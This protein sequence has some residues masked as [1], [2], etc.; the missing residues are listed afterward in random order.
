MTANQQNRAG[1]RAIIAR[2]ELAQ[3]ATS[4]LQSKEEVLQRERSRLAGH[5]GRSRSDW[6]RLCNEAS[7][8]LLRARVLGASDELTALIVRGPNPASVQADWQDSMGITYPGDV[9]CTPGAQFGVTGTAALLPVMIAYRAA[10]IAGTQHAGTATALERLDRELES[11]RR[12]R[13]AIGDHLVPRISAELHQLDLALDEQDREEAVRIRLA[14]GRQD[15]NRH[16]SDR[17]EAVRR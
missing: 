2:L 5:E 6:I 1:R 4:L 12:R 16:G 9:S 3:H 17:P 7:E 11:S 15:A 13:R 10:L 8:Q 14:S